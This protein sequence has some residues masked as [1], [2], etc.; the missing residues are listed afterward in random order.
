M[1]AVYE[2]LLTVYMLY[3]QYEQ[4]YV[5]KKIHFYI[6]GNSVGTSY[7]IKMCSA[8]CAPRGEGIN[9]F[10]IPLRREEFALQT[11]FYLGK[12]KI[13]NEDYRFLSDY[14]II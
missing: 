14:G 10:A 11:L 1:C 13:G 9:C 4:K 3:I 12:V 7:Y 5:K 6:I 2:L 8:R